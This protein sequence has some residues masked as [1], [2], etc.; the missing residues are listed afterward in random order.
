[1]Y[2]IAPFR[3]RNFAQKDFQAQ[4]DHGRIQT[5]HSMPEGE[6][7]TRSLTPTALV[8]RQ[9]NSSPKIS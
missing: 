1:M 5:V 2:G 9:A 4:I 6:T 3:L 8:A 7:L